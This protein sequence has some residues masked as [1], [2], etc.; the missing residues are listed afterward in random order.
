MHSYESGCG[1]HNLS[2]NIASKI[3]SGVVH[4]KVGGMVHEI[5][6]ICVSSAR[7]Y[8]NCKNLFPV[9]CRCCFPIYICLLQIKCHLVKQL[10]LSELCIR[11]LDGK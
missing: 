3:L 8:P 7:H 5:S 6:L 2:T 4:E 10:M 11:E 1:D 9:K